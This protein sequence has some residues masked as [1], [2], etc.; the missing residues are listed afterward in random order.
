MER[1]E[2]LCSPHVNV[3][4]GVRADSKPHPQHRSAV[5]AAWS[6]GGEMFRETPSR[7]LPQAV[8]VQTHSVQSRATEGFF[9][10]GLQSSLNWDLTP[11][12]N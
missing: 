9:Q 6:S 3:P 11:L 8:K 4:E 5:R 12:D 1:L 10:L 2:T 7:R